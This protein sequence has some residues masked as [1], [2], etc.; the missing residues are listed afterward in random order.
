M[1]I[2]RSMLPKFDFIIIINLIKVGGFIELT[3]VLFEERLLIEKGI[4]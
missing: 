3:E 2:I 1:K 4:S